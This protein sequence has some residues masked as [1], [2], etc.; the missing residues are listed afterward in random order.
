MLDT[1]REDDFDQLAQVASDICGTP[2][3]VVNLVDTTRQFFKAEVGLGVRSTP[4]E[5]AF[6]SHALLE[7]DVLVIPDA[8]KDA[9]L[10]CNPLVTQD[11]HLRAYAGALL[12]TAQ[13][14]PIG[15]ICVLDYKPRAFTD[16]QIQMLQ[17]LA[18]QTMAQFEL[19]RTIAEQRRLLER[20]TT[21]ERDKAKFERVVTQASDFIGMAN[22]RGK[23]V[24][25]NDAARTMMGIVKG[26]ALPEDVEQ[27]IAEQDRPLFRAEIKPLVKAGESCE[28]ELRLRNFETGEIF[29]ALYTMFPMR[30]EDGELSGFG[31]VTKDITERKEEE[32]RRGHIMSEAAHRMKN[33]LAVIEAIVSQTLRNAT[34]LAEGR[35]S[36]SRRVHALARAQD[37]LTAAEGSTADIISVIESALLPHDPGNDR[38]RFAGP[39]HRLSPQQ[40]LGL[41]LAIHELATNAAK[42]GAL[43]GETGN[44]RIDWAVSRE[45]DFT[46]EWQESGGA[47]VVTPSSTGFGS[48]LVRHLVAPYFSGTASHEFLPEGVRFTLEGKLP[49]GDL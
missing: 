37:L 45:G 23:V 44:V 46:L 34:S 29:P 16:Q 42:Y 9:R 3:G 7:E 47:P 6:C 4:L 48:K 43:K 20:A 40:S 1:P 38:I 39:S 31:V 30:S 8:T 36:I 33:T 15:T 22:A 12:K 13:G 26:A 2:I 28:R 21:A 32:E 14:L 24:Y 19:R 5:T 27:Y 25:L 11:P 17:F 18:K 10:D 41:S 49:I 35:E